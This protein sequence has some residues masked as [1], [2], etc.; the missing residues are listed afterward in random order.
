M[1][2]PTRPPDPSGRSLYER[3]G[4]TRSLQPRQGPAPRPHPVG[5]PRGDRRAWVVLVVAVILV[6]LVWLAWQADVARPFRA[7]PPGAGDRRAELQEAEIHR[8]DQRIEMLE[9]KVSAMQKLEGYQTL[10]GRRLP[11]IPD[12]LAPPAGKA[13]SGPRP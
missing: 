12:P 10:D 11:A 8:L 9:I 6:T 1:T 4:L 5:P 13:R 7:E 2:P 3:L